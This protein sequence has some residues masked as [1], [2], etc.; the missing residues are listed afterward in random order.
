MAFYLSTFSSVRLVGVDAAVGLLLIVSVCLLTFHDSIP[1]R[2]DR[3]SN[4]K[5]IEDD[6]SEGGVF[7]GMDLPLSTAVAEGV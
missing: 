5:S 3:S 1:K 2:D 7:V 6:V 4:T